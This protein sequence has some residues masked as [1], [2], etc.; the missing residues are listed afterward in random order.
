M[1]RLLLL[2][3]CS[4][5]LLCGADLA[6]VHTVYV[7]PMARGLDQYLANRI[8]GQGVFRVVT[9]PKLADAVVTDMIGEVFQTQLEN[10]SP[11]P[12][13]AEPAPAPE[14]KTPAAPT[15]EKAAAP[16]NPAAKPA[17][18]AAKPTEPVVVNADAAS[19]IDQ[20]VRR[21]K[22]KIDESGTVVSMFGETENKVAPPVSTFGRGKGTI[23]LVDAK[24]RQVV[25]STFDPSKGTRNNDLDRTA[26]DIVSRLKKDLKPKKP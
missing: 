22:R 4:G 11:T 25:W 12:K 13:P 1:K 6:G 8:S 15:A 24:S 21:S 18:P 19:A 5:A 9:D 23:F 17:D 16:A 2:L 3:G 26:S 10:I 7:M 14:T 20:P